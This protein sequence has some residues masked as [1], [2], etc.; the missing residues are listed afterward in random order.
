MAGS[1]S[2]LESESGRP[3]ICAVQFVAACRTGADANLNG[4]FP[5]CEFL[6]RLEQYRSELCRNMNSIEIS[7]TYSVIR[8]CSYL[9][10]RRAAREE[11]DGRR[12]RDRCR[13]S[14]LRVGDQKLRATARCS[15]PDRGRWKTQA[16]HGFG[17]TVSRCAARRLAGANNIDD[18]TGTGTL[19]WGQH[20]QC[21]P[22]N[23]TC[24][25]EI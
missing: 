13:R 2:T 17:A 19:L 12:W 24:T 22:Q 16:R 21:R 3:E 9:C 18:M 7:C 1:L 20:C 15:L 6:Q 11:S 10:A 5:L 8:H 4:L 23:P 14:S 25:S